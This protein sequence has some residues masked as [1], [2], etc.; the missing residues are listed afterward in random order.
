MCLSIEFPQ[1]LI[2]QAHL[3]GREGGN[4]PPLRAIQKAGAENVAPQPAKS[5]MQPRIKGVRFPALLMLA[6]RPQ[7]RVLLAASPMIRAIAKGMMIQITAKCPNRA[8]QFQ[9]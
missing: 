1:Q 7:P 9:A 3:P 2:L 8:V 4:S 6:L 5:P